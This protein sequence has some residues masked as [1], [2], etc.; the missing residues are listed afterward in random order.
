MHLC[1]PAET[2]APPTC[3]SN[4]VPPPETYLLAAFMHRPCRRSWVLPVVLLLAAAG[5]GGGIL[6]KR[7]LE[8]KGQDGGKR[9]DNLTKKA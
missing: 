7:L 1:H 4:Y 6:G 2:A 3:R 9:K 8:G 5:L